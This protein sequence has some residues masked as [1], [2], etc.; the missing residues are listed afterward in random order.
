MTALRRL[1]AIIII[2]LSIVGLILCVGGIIG[3]WVF[4]NALVNATT[5]ILTM[6]Q[7]PL[8]TANQAATAITNGITSIRDGLDSINQSVTQAGDKLN[9]S[10]PVLDFVSSTVGEQLAPKI[11]DV[12]EKATTL[13]DTV[14]GVNSTL[15][16]I[17]SIPG[18]NVPTFTDQLQAVG[19]R[20]T[21]A[22]TAV[23]EF[24]A[25]LANLKASAIEAS[26][27]AVT[28]R[29]AKIDDALASVQT[30]VANFQTQVSNM[31]AQI[32][33]LRTYVPIW[34]NIAAIIVTLVILWFAFGQLRLIV[35]GR[36]LFRGRPAQV[37]APPGPVSTPAPPKK[38]E[39]AAGNIQTPA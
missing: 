37:V 31:L 34:L 35:Y 11:D 2:L 25:Y 20:L 38:E 12:R 30:D 39:P 14:I 5:R 28:S 6:A 4:T 21:A 7:V 27:T 13:H 29:T 8:N 10:T 18:V 17:N 19:D 16:A 24:R 23:Q 22:R 36:S 26:V 15:E 9:Q 33:L 3:D 32:A 1:A